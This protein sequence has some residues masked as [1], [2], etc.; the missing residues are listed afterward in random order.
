MVVGKNIKGSIDC[1]GETID[2]NELS[3]KKLIEG[4]DQLIGLG[5]PINWHGHFVLKIIA[6]R[7]GQIDCLEYESIDTRKF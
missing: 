4:N 7:I 6:R 1:L 3:I 2:W 5:G